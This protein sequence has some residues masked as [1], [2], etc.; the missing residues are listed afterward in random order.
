M[1]TIH[2]ERQESFLAVL[3]PFVNYSLVHSMIGAVN[4]GL[5]SVLIPR[6]EPLKLAKYIQRYHI[7]HINSIPAY[8]EALLQIQNIEKYQFPD[9]GYL[10]Y[11]GEA[12]QKEIENQINTIMQKCCFKHKLQKGLGMTEL[13]GAATK[14]LDE[15][16]EIGSV[17]IPLPKMVCKIISTDSSEELQYGQEG[18][19]CIAGPTLM[20]GYYKNEDETNKIIKKHKDDMIWIHT[21]DLGYMDE[22]GALFITGRIKRLIVTNDSDGQVTKFFPD[23]IE[24]TI[25]SHPALEMCCVVG[26][27]DQVRINYPK[28]YVVLKAGKNKDVVKNEIREVCRQN[29]PGYMIP[30]EIEFMTD[31]PRTARGKIDYRALEKKDAA[32]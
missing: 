29:L 20:L 8:C 1:T 18:E 7:D 21:G 24:R 12:M 17:G 28:A 4:S 27:P 32:K 14:T 22:N 9:F 31:L 25:L 23:R 13:T 10:F 11:G 5:I 30:E 6:Y 3:P 2:Y 26:I 15:V 19:V 16:N